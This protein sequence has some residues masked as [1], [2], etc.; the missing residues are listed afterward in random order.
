MAVRSNLNA[1]AIESEG[2]NCAEQVWVA[3]NL[4]DRTLYLCAVYIAPDRVR[5]NDLIETHCRSVFTIMEKA[6]PVDELIVLGDFNLAGISWKPS[7]SGF[8]YPDP[9]RSVFHTGSV[10]L[11]DNYS[12]ATL[13]QIN[14]IV[15][16]N[17]RSL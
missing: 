9:T 7:H 4:S 3:V 15:N 13:S 10:N 2:W 5:D 1:R 6:T 17:N 14:H 11:L 8:L 16:E 12:A